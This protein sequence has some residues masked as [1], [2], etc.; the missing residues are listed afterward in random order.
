MALNYDQWATEMRSLLAELQEQDFGYPLGVNDLRAGAAAGAAALPPQLRDLYR[1]LD[2]ISLPDVHVGYFLD[3]AQ[4]VRSAADRGEP[5]VVD[6]SS[7]M[8][9]A[10]FGSDGGG[11]RFALAL[12]DGAVTYLPSSGEVRTGRYIPCAGAP[13]RRVAASVDD[14]AVRLKADVAAF[15]RGDDDHEYMAG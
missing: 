13:V 7:E 2:G 12:M 9:I 8:P 11:G 5:T 10:V 6:G 3:Q 1:S 15:V 14:F 4:R